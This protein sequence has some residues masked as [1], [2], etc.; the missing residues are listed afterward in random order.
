MCNEGE[1]LS[2]VYLGD[3]GTRLLWQIIAVETEVSVQY[4]DN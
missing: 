2:E 4:F 3:S 1:G